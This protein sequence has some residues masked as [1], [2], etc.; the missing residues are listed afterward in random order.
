VI[1]FNRLREKKFRVRANDL[2]VVATAFGMVAFMFAG[3]GAGLYA[4]G[5]LGAIA[6]YLLGYLGAQKNRVEANLGTFEFVKPWLWLTAFAALALIK[7]KWQPLIFF[8]GIGAGMA[9]LYWIGAWIGR[10]FPLE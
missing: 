9:L 10:R 6:A 8:G 2:F 7:G 1:D 5:I 3:I 4:M